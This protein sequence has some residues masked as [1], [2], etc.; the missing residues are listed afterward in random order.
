VHGDGSEV[1]ERP[2]VG[3]EQMNAV[4]P[5][6]VRLV[7]FRAVLRDELAGELWLDTAPRPGRGR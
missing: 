1:G 2:W 6:F 3:E 4:A 5:V 7:G